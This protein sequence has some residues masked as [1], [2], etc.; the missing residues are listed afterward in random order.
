MIRA[1]EITQG[2]CP[3]QSSVTVRERAQRRQEPQIAPVI[4]LGPS[5]RTHEINLSGPQVL[6]G[7]LSVLSTVGLLLWAFLNLWL[8]E[9]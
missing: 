5:I 8:F 1:E 4:K 2:N 6:V 7:F 3:I 9:P